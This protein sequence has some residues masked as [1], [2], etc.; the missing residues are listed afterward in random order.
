LPEDI[1]Q[2]RQAM[3]KSALLR[4]VEKCRMQK[5]FDTVSYR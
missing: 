3:R 2:S 4:R 1:Q 5:F